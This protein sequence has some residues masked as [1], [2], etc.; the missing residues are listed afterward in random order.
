MA[1][2]NVVRIRRL[3]ASAQDLGAAI[4]G[5][6]SFCRAKNLSPNTLVYYR[7]R[8]AAFARYV[9]EHHCECPLGEITAQIIRGF[10]AWETD[11]NSASTA[12][13]SY[14]TLNAFFS[15]LVRDG[16]LDRNP[17]DRVDKPRR[18]RAVIGTFSPEEVKSILA[19]CR[20]DFVG[21]RDRAIILTLLDCGLRASELCGL[22]L[23]DID[24]REQTLLVVGKGDKERIVP[25]GS[26]VR[27]VLGEYIGRRGDLPCR[28]LFVSVYGEPINR[29]RLRA[30]VR[31]RCEA[32][33][34]KGVRCSPHTFR[35]TFAVMFLRA[36]ADAF[37]L[38]KLLGH[39]DLAMTRRYCELSRTDVLEKHRLF[40]PADRLRPVGPTSGR[41][42]LK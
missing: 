39:S 35:H 29:H 12:N 42:R 32:A 11:R 25:F 26:A 37:T 31:R 30:I 24:W 13:H 3:G 5:F 34:I 20:N 10:V 17:V 27:R 38:Q 15:Y 28:E 36:G 22:R 9:A 19:T 14:T 41:K 21:V 4:Q 16:L 6:F 18:R 1:G 2:S 40:S 8:L 7:Q 33:G 23:E